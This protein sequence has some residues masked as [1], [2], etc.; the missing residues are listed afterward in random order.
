MSETAQQYFDNYQGQSLLYAPSPAREYLRGQCV[1]GV[2]FFVTDNGFPVIWADA[3]EWFS[4]GLFP[5]QYERI[6]YTPGM[7]LQP[8]DVVVWLPTLPGSGGAG[9]IAA[10]LTANAQTFVS[11]DQNWGGKTIHKVTH[12]Y[13]Y[14][15]G[16]LRFKG[17][18][19][20]GAPAPSGGE[21]DMIGDTDNEYARWEKLG[22]EV[23]GRTLSRDEFRAAAVG[24]TWLNAIE[25]LCDDA[26]ADRTQ[27]AQ[28][29]G[30]L[31]ETQGWQGNMSSMQDTINNQNQTITDLTTKLND[32]NVSNADK[33]KALTDSLDKI[34]N[35]NASLATTHDKIT[36]LMSKVTGYETNPII[37]A[38]NAAK[39]A[40]QKPSKIASLFASIMASV[41]KYKSGAAKKKT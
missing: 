37:K 14:V 29:L 24:K 12:N 28:D 10:V 4:D 17:G 1:Q 7:V 18:R 26:E 39:A 40:A 31:A 23:R 16:V 21:E 2:S 3:Y 41:G 15:A 19:G 27:Q 33:Q 36:D 6:P 34:A 9:H 13:S 32:A 35:D 22:Q 38:Q 5:D 8:N 11:V 25:I 30:Q 20:G